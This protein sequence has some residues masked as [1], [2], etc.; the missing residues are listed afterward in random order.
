MAHIETRELAPR[1]LESVPGSLQAGIVALIVLGLFAFGLALFTQPERAWRSYLFNWLFFTG[2]AQGAVVLSAVVMITKGLWSR[3]LRRFALSWGAFLPIGYLLLI[4][5]WVMAPEIFPWVEH[6]DPPGKAAYLNVPFMVIRQVVLL[7]A[8]LLLSLILMRTAL[9]PDVGLVRDGTEGK[10][11]GLYDRI[12]RNWRGQET[13]EIVASRR[14]GVLGPA[15]AILYA[16]GWSVVAWDFVMSLENHWFSTMIGPYVFMGAF[17]TGV[18]VTAITAVLY[19]NRTEFSGYI[20]PGHFHDIGKLTFGFC[21]FWAYLYFSQFIVIWYGQLPV[22]QA[23]FNH[24]FAEPFKVISQIVFACVFVLPFFGLMGVTPK[25]RP[26]ILTAFAGVVLFGMWLERYFLIYPSF[27]HGQETLPLG[28]QE[29]GP[30]LLFAG[31]LLAC[32]TLFA[33]RFPMIQ[34][35]Q[36]LGE[37][38]LHGVEVEVRQTI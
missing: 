10:L 6:P 23:F 30:A 9:R 7:G 24:R 8:L 29:L 38:E 3:P 34:V 13:E 26:A 22:E 19:S 4:P 11:R 1:R 5:M 20:A 14:I 28:W 15:L 21:V 33:Q 37:V 12:T 17:L 31:L 25:K 2:I 16:F 35:W 27:Y 36:P 18:A 32:H